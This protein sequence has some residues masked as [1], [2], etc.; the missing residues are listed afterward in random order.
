VP[1]VEAARRTLDA[2]A[3]GGAGVPLGGLSRPTKSRVGDP[4]SR[5]S[6]GLGRM[7]TVAV[8]CI[9]GSTDGIGRA[10]A[11]VLLADGHRVLVHAR[12]RERGK[13]VAKALGG[14]VALV[15]GD[16][17][18]ID[19]VRG[20]ADQAREHG[21]IDVWV[22][23]AGV[24]V[25]GSTPRTSRDGHETTFAVN[26]LAPHLLTHLL[27]TA[28]QGRLLRLGSGLA[29]SARPQPA[30]LGRQ[31]D[32]RRAYAESKACDVALAWNRRLPDVISVAVDPG[33]VKTKL[34]S[35]GAPGDVSPSADTIAF[36]CTAPDLASAPSGRTGRRRR[37]RT[38]AGP[39]PPGC[40]LRG[41]RSNGRCRLTA[42]T[43][44]IAG[45]ER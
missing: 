24:W 32:P 26:V 5:R 18:R 38:A 43:R 17:A 45:S 21:P 3:G 44:R 13:L 14:D 40:D 9:T 1:R 35:P 22:H 11:R 19:D 29:G 31:T 15:V 30:A 34:A 28:L 23:N 27:S 4:G 8:M 12:S 25:R 10:A 7:T 20:L 33:W 39:R 16:L 2:R 42:T 6:A 41:L 37:P 36:C